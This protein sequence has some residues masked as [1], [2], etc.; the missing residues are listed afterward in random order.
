MFEIFSK[1]DKFSSKTS[2]TDICDS[3]KLISSS[4]LDLER[5]S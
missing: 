2:Q 1:L 4:D 3:I 5:G